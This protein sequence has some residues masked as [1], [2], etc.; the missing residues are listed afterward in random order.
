MNSLVL[1]CCESEV[2]NVAFDGSVAESCSS[3]SR[4]VD[5]IAGSRLDGRLKMLAGS[6]AENFCSMG[7]AATEEFAVDLMAGLRSQP[8]VFTRSKSEIFCSVRRPAADRS[9][10]EPIAGRRPDGRLEA[11]SNSENCCTIRWSVAGGFAVDFIAGL[12]CI[13]K[14]KKSPGIKTLKNSSRIT[15]GGALDGIAC[16]RRPLLPR[17]GEMTTPY[18][19]DGPSMDG[20]LVESSNLLGFRGGDTKMGLAD[21]AI[22]GS[23]Q[24]SIVDWS[25][26]S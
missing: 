3:G 17:I 23:C 21:G 24:G 2:E 1:G 16:S 22:V 11:G 10:V 26:I 14:L 18:S 7:R 15:E 20:D 4:G 5:P 13:W 6:K 12:R 25:S 19:I 8:R 9:V